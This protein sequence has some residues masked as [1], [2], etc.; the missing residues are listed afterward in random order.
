MI[1][2]MQYIEAHPS[3][4]MLGFGQHQPADPAIQGP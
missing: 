1:G 3:V 4:A 2:G